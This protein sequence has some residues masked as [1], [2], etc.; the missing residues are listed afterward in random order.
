M[1]YTPFLETFHKIIDPFPPEQIHLQS[2]SKDEPMLELPCNL[3]QA[4]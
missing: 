1:E 4:T 3:G 2:E